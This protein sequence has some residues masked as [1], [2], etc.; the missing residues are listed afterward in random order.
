MEPSNKITNNIQ[1]F[2]LNVQTAIYALCRQSVSTKELTFCIE[3]AKPLIEKFKDY[4]IADQ[5]E[6][7]LYDLSVD[8]QIEMLEGEWVRSWDIDKLLQRILLYARNFRVIG[9]FWFPNDEIISV[10][11]NYATKINGVIDT[12]SMQ[13]LPVDNIEEAVTAPRQP[14]KA[15]YLKLKKQRLH[16]RSAHES[17]SKK[18][19]LC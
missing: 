8:S 10:Y 12:E 7:L 1:N 6:N 4:I 13:I 19:K 15:I 16:K 9:I 2:I 3:E 14:I 11:G 18:I 5:P 17:S